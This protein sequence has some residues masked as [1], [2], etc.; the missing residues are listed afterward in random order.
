MAIP[1]CHLY[2]RDPCVAVGCHGWQHFNLTADGLG[3][4]Q[5]SDE[6][7]KDAKGKCD[8][9]GLENKRES[10]AHGSEHL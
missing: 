5:G 9:K 3:P 10:I 1:V 4:Q 6:M 2:E 7:G 8:G